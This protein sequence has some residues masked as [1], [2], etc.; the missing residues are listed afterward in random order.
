MYVGCVCCKI[1]GW[2]T[3]V[4]MNCELRLVPLIVCAERLLVWL[5]VPLGSVGVIPLLWYH[6]G[7]YG[8]IKTVF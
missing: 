1:L 2:I 6:W 5:T 8:L 4:V 3:G 7:W